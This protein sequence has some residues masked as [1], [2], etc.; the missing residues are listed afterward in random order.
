[1]SGIRVD[2]YGREIPAGCKDVKLSQ[3]NAWRTTY[4]HIVAGDVVRIE[5]E[6]SKSKAAPPAAPKRSYWATV[7]VVENKG[8]VVR[9]VMEQGEIT[10][11]AA[12]TAIT[13]QERPSECEARLT[14]DAEARKASMEGAVT[15]VA[16]ARE[17][18]RAPQYGYGAA[19]AR[20][21]VREGGYTVREASDM[22]T[23]YQAM[24]DQGERFGSN[25]DYV[26][27]EIMS[28][29]SKA[30]AALLAEIEE[31]QRESHADGDGLMLPDRYSP[32]TLQALWDAGLVVPGGKTTGNGGKLGWYSVRMINADHEEALVMDELASEVLAEAPKLITGHDA[33]S[34]SRR[35]DECRICGELVRNHARPNIDDGL[36]SCYW[37]GTVTGDVEVPGRVAQLKAWRAEAREVRDEAEALLAEIEARQAAI[38]A[39]TREKGALPGAHDGLFLPEAYSMGTLRAL[40]DAGRIVSGTKTSGNAGNLGWYS[41]RMIEADHAEALDMNADMLIDS[42]LAEARA[43]SV[44]VPTRA[45][46]ASYAVDFETRMLL[47]TRAMSI[48][49]TREGAAELM[50]RAYY[51]EPFPAYGDE[52]ECHP[53]MRRDADGTCEACEVERQARTASGPMPTVAEMTGDPAAWFEGLLPPVET[54]VAEIRQALGDGMTRDPWAALRGKRKATRVTRRGWQS[55]LNRKVR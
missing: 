18:T 55:K 33:E 8:R 12:H 15:E 36:T 41:V 6:G 1:M 40:V 52:C 51:I 9:L 53:A 32:A 16:K 24:I 3:S 37:S 54:Q 30:K 2:R 43:A 23:E 19:V 42:L 21:I 17:A 31:W 11:E 38:L 48:G 20:M 10:E 29:H 4:A 47:A 44:P 26:A 34:H 45:G 22:A 50:D 27:W 5:T 39:D 46:D 35:G 25:V 28:A 49:Y 7:A 14:V 13:R